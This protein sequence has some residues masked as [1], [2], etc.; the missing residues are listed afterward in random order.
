MTPL[1]Q[2]LNKQLHVGLDVCK[3]IEE[4]TYPYT[5]KKDIINT[6]KKSLGYSKES[7]SS[8]SDDSF[9][10]WISGI[11]YYHYILIYCDNCTKCLLKWNSNDRVL[12]HRN[13]EKACKKELCSINFIRLNP[14]YNKIMKKVPIE[15]S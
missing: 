14:F 7:F 12:L 13:C 9:F 11:H 10:I 2:E 15:H 1:L 5:T 4:Y 3:I 6:F 8:L